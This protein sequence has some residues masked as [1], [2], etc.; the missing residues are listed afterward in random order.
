MKATPSSASPLAI[1]MALVLVLLF[2]FAFTVNDS[3]VHRAPVNQAS[4][5]PA[6]SFT[7]AND[8]GLRTYEITITS[9][10][11]PIRWSSQQGKHF[12]SA[13]SLSEGTRIAVWPSSVELHPTTN[14]PIRVRAGTV[15]FVIGG[16]DQPPAG[17]PMISESAM[18]ITMLD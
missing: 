9:Q 2:S 17:T 3:D 12:A 18:P 13:V 14:Q 15:F 7:N 4:L 6:L 8:V 10:A 1:S 16:G 11:S 5:L